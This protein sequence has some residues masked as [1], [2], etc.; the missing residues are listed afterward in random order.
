MMGSAAAN[1]TTFSLVTEGGIATFLCLRGI[2]KGG[3]CRLERKACLNLDVGW[4]VGTEWSK[5][6]RE[7]FL[8]STFGNPLQRGSRVSVLYLLRWG[9]RLGVS[10]V[11]AH[12]FVESFEQLCV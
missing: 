1:V 7:E 9:G 8:Y 11:F 10:S 6:D 3:S 5:R 2:G 12:G 4:G